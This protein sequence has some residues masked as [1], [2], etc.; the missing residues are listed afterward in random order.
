MANQIRLLLFAFL[1]LG[2]SVMSFGEKLPLKYTLSYTDCY[3]EYDGQYYSEPT[4][5]IQ[6][7]YS[8]YACSDASY[9]NSSCKR[10]VLTCWLPSINYT[11]WCPEAANADHPNDDVE[12]ECPLPSY[13]IVSI[14]G[15]GQRLH[16]V[17]VSSGSHNVRLMPQWDT[18]SGSLMGSDYRGYSL[19]TV[20]PASFTYNGTTYYVTEIGDFAFVNSNVKTIKI[21]SSVTKFG[22]YC[23]AG[24]DNADFKVLQYSSTSQTESPTDH[25]AMFYGSATKTFGQGMFFGCSS[26]TK[27]HL[28]EITQVPSG[29]FMN[30][31]NLTT[32]EFKNNSASGTIYANADACHVQSVGGG[33]FAGCKKLH[34]SKGSWTGGELLIFTNLGSNSLGDEAFYRCEAL[35]RVYFDC[36][37]S[38]I[39]YGCFE[40]CTSFTQCLHNSDKAAGSGTWNLSGHSIKLT[41]IGR[42]AF[43]DCTSMTNF[44]GVYSQT[45]NASTNVHTLWYSTDVFYHKIS[46][47]GPEAFMNTNLASG[48][49]ALHFDCDNLNVLPYKA[50]YGLKSSVCVQFN[51]NVGD[52][53]IGQS[54]FEN[55]KITGVLCVNSSTHPTYVAKRAFYS[56]C[57][58]K[59]ID[60]SNMKLIE[61]E[62]FYECYRTLKVYLQD[63]LNSKANYQSTSVPLEFF[64]INAEESTSYISSQRSSRY[65]KY[66]NS[67]QPNTFW[68]CA[69]DNYGLSPLLLPS[70]LVRIEHNA[71]EEF[72]GGNVAVI[73][74]PA[75]VKYIDKQ[76]FNDAG[77]EPD[78]GEYLKCTLKFVFNTATPPTLEPNTANTGEFENFPYFCKLCVPSA[79][80][81]T[82]YRKTLNGYYM[83]TC[84]SS[85]TSYKD[86]R[87]GFE[88]ECPDNIDLLNTLYSDVAL[89]IRDEDDEWA[90]AYIIKSADTS[91]EHVMIAS[92]LARH[93]ERG[94]DGSSGR[95]AQIIPANTPVMLLSNMT[96]TRFVEAYNSY[97]EN[98]FAGKMGMDYMGKSTS[99]TVPTI[100]QKLLYGHVNKAKIPAVSDGCGVHKYYKWCHS[101]LGDDAGGGWFY[102]APGGGLF[103]SGDNRCWLVR[104]FKSEAEAKAFS[105]FTFLVE[106][107]DEEHGA[108]EINSIE[109]SKDGVEIYD[110][111]DNAPLY[112]LS[113]QRIAEPQKG[114]IYIKNGRKYLAK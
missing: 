19:E 2:F 77:E 15:H 91:D 73:D 94:T 109:Q 66:W 49:E 17:P 71:F 111:Q 50:F 75:S 88:V 103:T 54:C 1:F 86:W 47:I 24:C 33:A 97:Y 112:N 35:K 18:M 113:G 89:V 85:N 67:I 83:Y 37:L 16:Y 70:D 38:T 81:G 3:D 31:Y 56:C 39:P 59:N 9:Y 26:L 42:A 13:S 32:I 40:G 43:K 105:S 80:L 64:R 92:L 108:T 34:F 48:Y 41:T 27:I 74:I 12:S 114:G 102:G 36:A 98:H 95:G 79:A 57:S 87:L 14:D 61:E 104:H 55:A 21:P 60:F 51:K 30:C 28:P 46:S 62:A 4:Y 29:C 100:S 68:G 78:E 101:E 90:D 58:L 110:G 44:G 23:F 52:I 45:Y 107:E 53:T 96:G 22:N 11:T 6:E 72:Y 76:A 7:Y 106:S 69:S 10:Y 5:T 82:Y 65:P 84:A 93:G 63:E 99:V 20:V 25:A 8:I